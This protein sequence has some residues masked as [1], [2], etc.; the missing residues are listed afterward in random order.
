MRNVLLALREVSST[1]M[2]VLVLIRQQ[3]MT[4]Q[5]VESDENR[6]LSRE[7]ECSRGFTTVYGSADHG[8]VPFF[9]RGCIIA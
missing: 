2:E 3:T 1:V 6:I 4:T 9:Y 7:S 8:A 5:V